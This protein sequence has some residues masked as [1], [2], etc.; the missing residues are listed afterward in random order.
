MAQSYNSLRKVTY[1]PFLKLRPVVIQGLGNC[2]T[3]TMVTWGHVIAICNFASWLL[4]S[5]VNLEKLNSI[6]D[7]VIHVMTDSGK[8][9]HEN[10]IRSGYMLTRLTTILP[11]N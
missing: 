10:E 4:I 1:N 5:L 7:F 6:N 11:S 9:S 3:F 2:L 8:N